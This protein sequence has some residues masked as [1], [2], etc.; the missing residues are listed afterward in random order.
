VNQKVLIKA[1]LLEYYDVSGCYIIRPWAYFIW[2]QIKDKLDAE[3]KKLGVQNSYFP[4][5]VSKAALHREQTHI[6]DFAPEVIVIDQLNVILTVI[7][8]FARLGRMGNK[9]WHNRS[10]TADCNSTN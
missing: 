1:E 8:V 3:I 10:C 9:K 7:D 6:T 4:I 2:E 5:F